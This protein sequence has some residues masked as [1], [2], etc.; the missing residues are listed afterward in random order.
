MCLIPPLTASDFCIFSDDPYEVFIISYYLLINSVPPLVPSNSVRS[1]QGNASPQQPLIVT[2]VRCAYTNWRGWIYP[3]SVRTTAHLDIVDGHKVLSSRCA[4]A[5]STVIAARL[6]RTRQ[7][8]QEICAW[9]PRA[10]EKVILR[11]RTSV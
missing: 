6:S 5:P 8:N 2:G 1:R 10:E 9:K 7:G 11:L 3:S 4:E